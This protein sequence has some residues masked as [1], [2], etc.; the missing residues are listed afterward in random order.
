MLSMSYEGYITDAIPDPTR[1]IFLNSRTRLVILVGNRIHA[2]ES[3]TR[4]RNKRCEPNSRARAATLAAVVYPTPATALLSLGLCLGD[5][6][7]SRSHQF[8]V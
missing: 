8:R 5:V 7:V 6:S 4:G 3:R 1:S 2:L